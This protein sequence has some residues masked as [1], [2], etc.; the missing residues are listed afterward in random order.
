MKREGI[1]IQCNLRLYFR[2]YEQTFLG[3]QSPKLEMLAA[4]GK[5]SKV[6]A[7]S[8]DEWMTVIWHTNVPMMTLETAPP[9]RKPA[10]CSESP[11]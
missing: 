5:E 8:H 7:I 11:L 4:Y 9:E 10:A 6:K 3:L 1:A 2:P